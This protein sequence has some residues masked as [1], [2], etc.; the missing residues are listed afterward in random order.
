M[1]SDFSKCFLILKFHKELE[2]EIE[3]KASKND[4]INECKEG[5]SLDFKRNVKHCGEAR[6]TNNQENRSIEDGLPL[7]IKAN[8]EV[9]RPE[10][11][12]K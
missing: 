9:F 3:S 4:V 11:I 6:V 5:T 10:I 2:K 12:S 1:I 7:A 8:N